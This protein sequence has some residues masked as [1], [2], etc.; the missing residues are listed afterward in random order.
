[1]R[2]V[3]AAVL[4]V[5]LGGCVF[6]RLREDVAAIDAAVVVRGT[7]EA[8][9]GNRNP[10]FVALFTRE[11]D[12]RHVLKAYQL[13]YGPGPFSFLKGPG[14]YYLFAFE[15]LNQ[16]AVYQR[17][18]DVA[19]Y[20]APTPIT[21][22][23]GADLPAFAITLRSAEVAKQ[24]LPELYTTA[25]PVPMAL[26]RFRLGEVVDLGDPMFGPEIG[27]LGLW[28]PVQFVRANHTGVFFLEPYDPQKIPV[29]LIHGIAGSA[30]NWQYLVSRMDRARFQP[31]LAQYPSGLRLDLVSE[32]LRRSITTLHLRHRFEKLYV[33]AHSMGGLV[34][35]DL[36]EKIDD[37]D[38]VAIGLLVTLSTPWQGHAAAQLGVDRAPAVVPAWYDMAPGS[39]YIRRVTGTPLPA[40]VPYYLL[41]SYRRAPS[42]ANRASSDG[43]V[44]LQSQLP[45]S[46]QQEAVR[47][48]GYDES[49]VGILSS[50]PVAEQLNRILGI[51]DQP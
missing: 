12:G 14:A 43:T 48:T 4:C 7:V 49:H 31:W 38:G 40:E 13:R 47:V 33:V 36:I 25:T 8:E 30:Q 23:P 6:Q 18:E 44:T 19:W 32:F 27:A 5:L 28:Q 22:R 3:L 29:L 37:R 9:P 1:M 2:R 51:P 42:L 16:D 39:P 20:G 26:E 15:D 24:Q 41:F 46:L 50:A 21:V 34:A 11:E 45:L 17:T 10:I 35:R